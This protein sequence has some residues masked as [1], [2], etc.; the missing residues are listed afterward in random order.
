MESI[1]VDIDVSK[2]QLDVAVLPSKEA[3]SVPRDSEGLDNLVRRL[4]AL[5]PKLVVMEATGGFETVVAAALAAAG[6]P[7]AVVNPQRVREFAK[8]LGR[9]AKTNRLDAPVITAYGE[10][11]ARLRAY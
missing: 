6:L 5:A 2:D 10:A 11:G 9:L 8:A 7:V 3:F 4:V 1:I